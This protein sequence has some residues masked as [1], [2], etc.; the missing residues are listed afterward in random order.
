MASR[1]Y[2]HIIFDLDGTIFD[3]HEANMHGLYVVLKEFYP[4]TQE[5]VESLGRF[6]GIPGK[7]TLLSLE[8]PESMHE[9]MYSRWLEEVYKREHTA[10]VYDGMLSVLRRLK[11]IGF[12]LGIVTSRVKKK[13]GQGILGDYMPP[14]IKE[15]FDIAVCA[16]DVARPKPYPDSL[17]HYMELTGA[18]PDEI[19][20]IGDAYTDLMCAND[21]GVDF[22]LALWGYC[23]KERLRCRYYF[24]NP[25]EI[26][27]AVK[28][29]TIEQ[30]RWFTLSLELDQIASA[31][32]AYSKD[33]YD[34]E[35]YERLREIAAEILACHTDDDFNSIN[36][37]L[38]FDI[39]YRTPKI[40][41]RAAIFNEKGEILL[42]EENT[43]LFSLPGGWCEGSLSVAQNTV[44]EVLEEAGLNVYVSRLIAIFDRK[45]HN[46][47]DL[48]CG[49]MKIFLQ[50][51][52]V[53]GKFE[54]NIETKSARYF[55]LENLPVDRLRTGTTSYDQLLVCF[56]AYKSKNWIALVE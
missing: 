34:K 21:A 33:V 44:K 43:G 2:K 20:F 7:Q 1:A 26:L 14:V 42:V 55:S 56:E 16:D 15:F 11:E 51:E 18:R 8:I 19:L 41:T 39:G 12:R 31:G 37:K 46:K 36:E 6:F 52:M 28:R 9:K 47:P 27:S 3:T 4:E 22:G 25:F 24:S 54:P 5:T 13:N 53:S 45:L 35:R 49:V 32:L 17:W 10:S 38:S 30:D 48:A 50:C 40:D 23:Q 29:Y